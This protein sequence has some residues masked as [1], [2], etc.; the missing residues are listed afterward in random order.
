[1]ISNLPM[2]FK[3]DHRL[4]RRL[5]SERSFQHKARS[6]LYWLAWLIDTC[7][8][9]GELIL[10]PMGGSGSI[11]LAATKQRPVLTGDIEPHWAMLQ[12]ENALRIRTEMMFGAT[13]HVFQFDAAS[14]PLTSDALP[15]IVTS[16]PYFDLFSNWNR[17][18][19][20]AI[21]GRSDYVGETGLCY[22]FHP[23]QIGNVH[24][25]ENYLASMRRVY[26]ECWRV[27]RPGG[28]F[29]LIV[30]DRVKR[31][32][33]VPITRDTA[34]MCQANGFVL[35]NQYQR[36][37]IPSHF[38]NIHASRNPDDPRVDT[39]TALVFQKQN[40]RLP[41]K[42]RFALVQSPSPNSSPGRQLFDKQ[43]NYA[44][45][46]ADEVL[47]FT[48]RGIVPGQT[49][50]AVW[51]GDHPPKARDRREWA[52]SIAARLVT[53]CGLGAGDGIALYITDRYARY[54][55][56]RLNSFGT[57]A[58]IPTAHCNFGQKLAWFKEQMTLLEQGETG[59]D[60]PDRSA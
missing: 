2:T 47:I 50:N 40:H 58:T 24:V 28:I 57:R 5:F 37:T 25:Y 53:K 55:K 45:A 11:L 3:R 15:A 60:P 17:R 23:R 16:P 52:H 31:R 18:S 59:F 36:A 19:G 20:A 29:V 13:S 1:M 21:D 54:L 48:N 8:A 4:R 32:R 12:K 7:T 42:Q 27:L 49:L 44:R 56:Q 46:T 9:P 33:I 30:G 38:R 22:G 41:A 14:L 51:A 34:A 10:D 26:R 6:N 43:I 35:T 39:E